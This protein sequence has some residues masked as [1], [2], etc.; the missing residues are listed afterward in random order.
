MIILNRDLGLVA[1]SQ[2]GGDSYRLAGAKRRRDKPASKT[3]EASRCHRFSS[4]RLPGGLFLL[5]HLP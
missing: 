1:L 3:S 2:I 4:W 5:R